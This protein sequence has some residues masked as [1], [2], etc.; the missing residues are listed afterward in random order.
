LI[1]REPACHDLLPQLLEQ[2]GVA[3]HHLLRFSRSCAL[4]ERRSGGAEKTS[5]Y[6]K[7]G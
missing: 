4:G 2:S 7:Q 5:E 3:L 1:R 6:Y